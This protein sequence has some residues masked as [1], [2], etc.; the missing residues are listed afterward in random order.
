MIDCRIFLKLYPLIIS[1]G[2]RGSS[3]LSGNQLKEREPG[4]GKGEMALA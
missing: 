2:F 4:E 3:E 1:L